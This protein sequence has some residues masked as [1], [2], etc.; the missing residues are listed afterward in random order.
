MPEDKLQI[1]LEELQN[2]LSIIA[3]QSDKHNTNL[4]VRMDDCVE[5]VDQKMRK[6]WNWLIGTVLT[7]FLA[8]GVVGFE[9]WER[10][11]DRVNRIHEHLIRLEQRQNSL[12]E[13]TLRKHE[14]YDK[15][16]LLRNERENRID[17]LLRQL[18]EEIDNLHPRG[19]K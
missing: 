8:L 10:Q 4:Q 6:R 2:E 9:T 5:K 15:I 13:N 11:Y 16:E 3:Q 14:L 12:K 19:K 18:R 7:V 1:I 17:N